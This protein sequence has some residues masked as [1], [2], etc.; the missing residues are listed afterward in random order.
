MLLF[1]LVPLTASALNPWPLQHREG[2]FDDFESAALS[3][4]NRV[5]RTT[6]FSPDYWQR[7][8]DDV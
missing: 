8:L 7:R 3:I 4:V 6:L 5:S 2:Q 1:R